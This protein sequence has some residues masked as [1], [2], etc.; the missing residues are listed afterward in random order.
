MSELQSFVGAFQVISTLKISNF[1]RKSVIFFV[2]SIGYENTISIW[3]AMNNT[4][5]DPPCPIM[6]RSRNRRSTAY[7]AQTFSPFEDSVI[8]GHFLQYYSL[9]VCRFFTRLALEAISFPR[10]KY[11]RNIQVSTV[12]WCCQARRVTRTPWLLQKW[13]SHQF[14]PKI[15]QTHTNSDLYQ[16]AHTILHYAL[17]CRVVRAFELCYW[18]MFPMSSFVCVCVCRRAPARH[19]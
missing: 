19:S 7:I 13:V 11:C 16:C 17:R 4:S 10:K 3:C 18:L 12:A 5:F 1:Q 8:H 15:A 2:E 14:R 6:V 9:N